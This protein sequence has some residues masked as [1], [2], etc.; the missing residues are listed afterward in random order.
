MTATLA[1]QIALVELRI[2]ALEFLMRSTLPDVLRNPD[3]SE[4]ELNVWRAVLES[5]RKLNVH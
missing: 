5:L 3:D 1:E 4:H 2:E